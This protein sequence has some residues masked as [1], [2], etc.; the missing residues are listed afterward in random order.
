MSELLVPLLGGAILLIVGR[1]PG[2]RRVLLPVAL[3][4]LAATAVQQLEILRLDAGQ[5][6]AAPWLVDDAL[7]TAVGWFATAIGLLLALALAPGDAEPHGTP[8]RLG[9]MLVAL[10]SLMLVAAAN[11]LIVLFAAMEGVSCC[12]LLAAWPGR[13]TGLGRSDGV[14][15]VAP[16][17][18]S[19]LLFL[20]GITLIYG[21][22]ASTN[23]PEIRAVLSG[24]YAPA[25]VSRTIG[26]GSIL[27]VAAVVLVFAGLGW[28]L[29]VVPFQFG[30]AEMWGRDWRSALLAATVGRAAAFV[31]LARLVVAALPGFEEPARLIAAL[32]AGLT[33]VVAGIRALSRTDVRIVL[34][35]LV[36][37][38]GGF[39]LVGI[40]AALAGASGEPG[41][42]AVSPGLAAGFAALAVSSAATVGAV[43]VLLWHGGDSSLQTTDDLAGLARTS[44][45]AAACLG[46]T[47]L[48]LAGVPPLIGFWTQWSLA[49][50]A[51]TAP[52]EAT[53]AGTIGLDAGFVVLTLTAASGTLFSAIAAMRLL[54]PVLLVGPRGRPP[55]SAWNAG[56]AAILASVT[57]TLA[58]LMPGRTNDLLERL[59]S[60]D[61]PPAADMDQPR[62]EPGARAAL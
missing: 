16:H 15:T 42:S 27:G 19:S 4:V 38:Q 28:R 44:P 53:G 35:D 40:A 57:I 33:F 2:R 17:L 5:P 60:P 62:A 11:D 56:A 30:I 34:A 45:A 21:L 9:W 7:T 29:A 14:Q 26:R 24:S 8:N 43:S 47:L 51:L 6:A 48:A 31:V 13:Q 58:S 12:A 23:V 20:L 50:A 18:V 61:V 32:L 59:D 25:D 3:L 46:V 22:T 55:V 41:P 54:E 1:L 39:L 52:A 49:L 36:V 37:L 10:A